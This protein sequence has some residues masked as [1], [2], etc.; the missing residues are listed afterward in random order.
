M[1]VDIAKIGKTQQIDVEKSSGIV[2]HDDVARICTVAKGRGSHDDRGDR[3]PY[4]M[5]ELFGGRWEDYNNHFIVQAAGCPLKCPYC[6]VDNLKADLTMGADELVERF[7]SFKA[8][9]EPKFGIKLK[10]FHF[11]GGA[12]AIYCEFWKELRQALDRHNLREV[13][14]F[15]DVILVEEHF[16]NKRPWEFLGLHHFLLT[17]CLKG[18]NPQ[19]FRRNTGSDLFGQ[20]LK[21]LQHYLPARNFY[22]T[23]IGH[24]QQDLERIYS[25]V[26]KDRI[27]FLQIVD[28]EVTKEKM[29]VQG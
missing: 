3:S 24:D 4:R 29:S 26:P 14:L 2:Y 15:S 13:V 21:E 25:I 1:K 20:S 17:G 23:L 12:P 11:M 6:Y 27:D 19:N 16:V 18:T 9:V 22:L 10:V 28:Y 5:A 7:I 8:E